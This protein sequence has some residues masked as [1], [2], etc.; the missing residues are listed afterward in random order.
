M[1]RDVYIRVMLTPGKYECFLG[2]VRRC[3]RVALSGTAGPQ[4]A[5][6]AGGRE[7]SD[8]LLRRVASSLYGQIVP[9]DDREKVVMYGATLSYCG[10]VF[11]FMWTGPTGVCLCRKDGFVLE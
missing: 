7:N 6:C 9:V 5:C 4:G 11:F 10:W 8:D 2:T 3:G 1:L